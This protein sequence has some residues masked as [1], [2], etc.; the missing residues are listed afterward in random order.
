M[1]CFW[2]FIKYRQRSWLFLRYTSI[3]QNLFCVFGKH[4][5]WLIIHRSNH[6]AMVPSVSVSLI[7]TCAHILTQFFIGIL[8][9]LLNCC[10]CQWSVKFTFVMKYTLS[11]LIWLYNSF[12]LLSTSI[13]FRIA[14][15]RSDNSIFFFAKWRWCAALFKRN[16]RRLFQ[17]CSLF[18]HF[19]KA[20]TWF[21]GRKN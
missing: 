13:L 1:F 4:L 8:T 11:I 18:C 14:P 12:I 5:K 20:Y 9:C 6:R 2:C 7:V 10:C 19:E 17:C 21:M 16:K 15:D 3:T